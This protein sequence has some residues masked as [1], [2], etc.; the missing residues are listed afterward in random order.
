MINRLYVVRE[1]LS[2]VDYGWLGQW[3]VKVHPFVLKYF[4]IRVHNPYCEELIELNV[5]LL[6]FLKLDDV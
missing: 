3:V 2:P 4:K 6:F 1:P 5:G